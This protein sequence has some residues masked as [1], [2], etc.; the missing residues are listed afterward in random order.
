MALGKSSE[1][2]VQLLRALF[3]KLDTNGDDLIS[4]G[5]LPNR[6]AGVRTVRTRCHAGTLAYACMSVR[7]AVEGASAPACRAARRGRDPACCG[8]SRLLES[9]ARWPAWEPPVQKG[10]LV[11]RVC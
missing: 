4:L 9:R 11:Y 6:H 5:G 1:S 2:R 3:T 8:G 7:L 10:S